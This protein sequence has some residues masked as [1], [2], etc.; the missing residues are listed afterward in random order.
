MKAPPPRAAVQ[1]ALCAPSPIVSLSAAVENGDG[2]SL[3]Q[4]NVSAPKPKG[5][6]RFN[7]FCVSGNAVG[8]FPGR[9]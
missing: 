6:G 1:G 4:Q 3:H 2:V 7:P 8:F 5:R 9:S